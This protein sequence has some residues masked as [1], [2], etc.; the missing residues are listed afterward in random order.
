MVL[1]G[2]TS[3]GYGETT[4]MKGSD[5]FTGFIHM[6]GTPGWS[7]GWSHGGSGDLGEQKDGRVMKVLLVSVTWDTLLEPWLVSW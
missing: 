1:N 2:F 6:H 4:V 3:F 7:P 5:S